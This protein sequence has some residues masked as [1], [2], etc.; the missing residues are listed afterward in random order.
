[1]SA[2]RWNASAIDLSAGGC[3]N[4][5]QSAVNHGLKKFQEGR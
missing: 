1:M 3:R 4:R 5:S 2:V